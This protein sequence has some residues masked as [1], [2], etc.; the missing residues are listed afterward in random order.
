MQ[1]FQYAYHD[2]IFI[3]NMRNNVALLSYLKIT[4]PHTPILSH[5]PFSPE[6]IK[7]TQ[8]THHAPATYKGSLSRKRITLTIEALKRE[9]PTASLYHTWD[10]NPTSTTQ[11][12]VNNIDLVPEVESDF[13]L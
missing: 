9:H 5:T 11:A 10:L 6:I 12:D 3:P 1:I 2:E 7:L 4:Y 8:T 13:Q